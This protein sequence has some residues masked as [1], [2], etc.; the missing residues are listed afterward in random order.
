MI[1]KT[2]WNQGSRP[3]QFRDGQ[4]AA[5]D[6]PAVLSISIHDADLI[7]GWLDPSCFQQFLDGLDARVA[8]ANASHQSLQGSRM[9]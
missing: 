9:L 2:R 5:L 7:D 4:L 3:S 8:D 1:L 6:C